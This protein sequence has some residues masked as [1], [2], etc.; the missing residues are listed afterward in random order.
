MTGSESSISIHSKSLTYED[1]NVT[2]GAAN[3]WS[4]IFVIVIPAILLLC[5]GFILY[6]RRKR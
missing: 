4:L 3:V 5:G 6:R 2:A 1:L